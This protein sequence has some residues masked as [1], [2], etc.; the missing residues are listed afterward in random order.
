MRASCID[1]FD[2]MNCG[3]AVAFCDTELSTGYWASGR[4]V[5]DIS[6][7]R[8]HVSLLPLS[9]RFLRNNRRAGLIC[10]TVVSLDDLSSVA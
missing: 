3:A 9:N 2:A 8:P 10:T 7:V 1:A 6:K 4:N 5:Y